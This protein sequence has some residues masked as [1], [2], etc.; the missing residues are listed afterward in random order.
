LRRKTQVCEG[1]EDVNL[2]NH[3]HKKENEEI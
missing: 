3:G 1:L 2:L